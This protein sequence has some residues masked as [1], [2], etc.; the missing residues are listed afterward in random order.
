MGTEFGANK[1]DG[2]ASPCLEGVRVHE[3]V[4]DTIAATPRVVRAAAAHFKLAGDEAGALVA[5]E[6]ALTHARAASCTVVVLP[7][8]A[9]ALGAQAA[10]GAFLGGIAKVCERL[11]IA[12]VVAVTMADGVSTVLIDRTGTTVACTAAKDHAAIVDL[13]KFGGNV[14]LRTGKHAV[15]EVAGADVVYQS[16]N[17]THEVTRITNDEGAE[18]TADA[19]AAFSLIYEDVTPAKKHHLKTGITFVVAAAAK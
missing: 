19:K 14:A 6:R 11:E 5:C 15:K 8:H 16:I 13:Y 2:Y 1:A 17:E 12:A 3:Y 9:K 18:T 4:R 10:D 7:G